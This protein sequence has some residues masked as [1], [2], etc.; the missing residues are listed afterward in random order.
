MR[1]LLQVPTP[2][3]SDLTILVFTD[4]TLHISRGL[5]EKDYP[6]NINKLLIK[7]QVPMFCEVMRVTFC[8]LN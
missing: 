5:E 6:T 7:G 2:M 1:Q 8:P 4:T 3:I